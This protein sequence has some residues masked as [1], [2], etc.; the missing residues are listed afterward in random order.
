MIFQIL[1]YGLFISKIKD[2]KFAVGFFFFFRSEGVQICI[3][4]GQI[5]FLILYI[6][7]FRSGG[8]FEPL[9]TT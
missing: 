1:I 8:L 4:G 9:T 7:N 2:Q 5:F 3:I 6:Y